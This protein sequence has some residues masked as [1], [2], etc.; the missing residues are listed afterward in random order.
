GAGFLPYNIGQIPN[1]EKL[2]A[3]IRSRNI[4]ATIILQAFAQ[5]KDIYKDKANIIDGNCDTSIFLGGKE[6]TTI[7]SL[8]E[9]LGKETI[10]DYNESKTRSNNDSFGQNYSKLG[11]SLMTQNEL[12]TME[13]DECIVQ[14]IGKKPFK[15]KKYDI[16]KHPRYKFHSQGEK[17]WFDIDKYLEALKASKNQQQR[18]TTNKQE[19]QREEPKLILTTVNG[20]R[21]I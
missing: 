1:F 21:E 16:T 5:L 9:E 13:R 3:T 12:L 11:R 6:K 2:I 18:N 20:S 8:S 4:S 10:N 17:Y 14:I 15:D 7:K 19:K